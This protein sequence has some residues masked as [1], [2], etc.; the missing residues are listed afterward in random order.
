MQSWVCCPIIVRANQRIA[1][2]MTKVNFFC[3]TVGILTFK[4]LFPI[5]KD[6]LA[7]IIIICNIVCSL[8]YFLRTFT[9]GTCLPTFTLVLGGIQT[10][11]EPPSL[12]HPSS[13]VLS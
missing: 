4:Q 12:Q 9:D 8:Y 10:R 6:S 5:S 3:F 7:F 1:K 13:G 2:A 11:T